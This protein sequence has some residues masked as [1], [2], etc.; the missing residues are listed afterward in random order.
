VDGHDDLITRVRARA[1]DPERRVPAPCPHEEVDRAEVELGFSFPPLLRRLLTEVGDGGFGPG[2]GIVGI[3]GWDESGAHLVELYRDF[4]DD[5]DGTPAD[6]WPE[7]LLPL[8]HNGCGDYA[9]VDVLSPGSPIVGADLGGADVDD[10][11]AHA[12]VPVAPTLEAWLEEWLAASTAN[13][14]PT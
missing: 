3:A 14:P 1:A 12:L 7:G 4:R 13:A 2:Y 6:G 11:L 5:A 10:L 9:C 8:V